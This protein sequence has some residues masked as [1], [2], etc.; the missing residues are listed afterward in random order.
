[1]GENHENSLE[2]NQ[3]SNHST[4]STVKKEIRVQLKNKYNKQRSQ[5]LEKI[6]KYSKEIKPYLLTNGEFNNGS[7]NCPHCKKS[8]I[9][10]YTL[11]THLKVIHNVKP[12]KC[13]ECLKDFQKLFELKQ[14]VLEKHLF[15]DQQ[16][17]A[18]P[19]AQ[20]LL[21]NNQN[22]QLIQQEF[23]Y[24]QK[25]IGSLETS[26]IGMQNN[27]NNE[28]KG[29]IQILQKPILQKSVIQGIDESQRYLSNLFSNNMQEILKCNSVIVSD[30]QQQL[31]A[32]PVQDLV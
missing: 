22:A 12:H 31:K 9:H 21:K 23:R 6:T 26:F 24:K 28:Q 4:E 30:I 15:Q 32:N 8:F 27:L 29:H 3:L 16:K 10:V 19:K 13:K 18:Q 1:M 11:Q 25:K 5:I 17:Q 14:H 7:Q 2:Q 20:N